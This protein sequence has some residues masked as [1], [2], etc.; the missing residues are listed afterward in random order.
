MSDEK[1]NSVKPDSTSI[2]RR[3][4]LKGSAFAF[5]T[6][7]AA[8]GIN[9]ATPNIVRAQGYDPK[10]VKFS[11]STPFSGQ[12]SF[13]GTI[14]GLKKGMEIYGGE[15]TITDASFDLKKQ[16]DQIASIVA[17]K[18][19]VFI[20]LPVDPV[21]CANAIQGAVDAGIPTFVL[22][23]I[24]PGVAANQFSLHDNFG[25]GAVTARWLANQLGGKGKIGA[26]QLPIN[27]TWNQRDFGMDFVLRDFPDIEVVQTWAFD[28]TGK[29]TPRAAADS[30]LTAHPDLD[31]IWTA[32]D[33]AGMEA[34]LGGMAAGRPD[35][36]TCGIDGGTAAFEN[37][38]SGGPFKLSCAQ[39]FYQQAV[40]PIYYA[41]QLLQG[42]NIPRTVLHP[43]YL[44]TQ[45]TLEGRDADLLARYDEPGVAEQLDWTRVL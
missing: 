12:D 39:V 44:V 29:V 20:V 33:N 7:A 1:T 24:I 8:S 23:S 45:E 11:F 5:A 15:L 31:A 42:K 32:W 9:L 27:E 13:A 30:M 38:N 14:G 6:V 40:T 19:D 34:A 25:M 4:L 10:K 22:D 21:G 37:I 16:N 2:D 35:L 28:P 41:H 26:M 43:S 17:S 18:P 36:I 3:T